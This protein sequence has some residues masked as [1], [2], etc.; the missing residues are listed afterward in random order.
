MG[1][2]LLLVG[3]GGHCRSVL[4]S[5]LAGSEFSKIG[6]ID[7]PENVGQKI[8]GVSVIGHD[9]D[10]RR[11]FLLGYTCA[12]VTIGSIGNPSRRIEFFREFEEIGFQIPNIIDPSATVSRYVVMDTGIFVGKNAVVNA[13]STIR[14]GAIINTRSVVEHD[15]VVGSF[16]HLAPGSVLGGNVRVGENTHVG[17]GSV[18]KQQITIGSNSII[19]MGSV[20]LENIEE[21]TIAYGNPCRVVRER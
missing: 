11:L 4:D 15:C 8:F 1:K 19:G 13:G 21:N 3:G 17:I 14:K 5:L 10:L 7:L 16:A 9:G 20:V 12:F 6:I 18:V 2:K